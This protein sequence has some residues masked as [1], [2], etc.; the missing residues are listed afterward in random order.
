MGPGLEICNGGALVGGVGAERTD[1]GTRNI[2]MMTTIKR[3]RRSTRVKPTSMVM[4]RRSSRVRK[5]NGMLDQGFT[6][7][8]TGVNFI[9]SNMRAS[10]NVKGERNHWKVGVHVRRLT[11]AGREGS[12]EL[13][14]ER[15]ISLGFGGTRVLRVGIWFRVGLVTPSRATT[16]SLLVHRRF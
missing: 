10:R 6:V 4:H 5:R 2:S 1:V 3:G 11:P 7:G 9:M 13:M 16:P 15:G 12:P 14:S 8:N